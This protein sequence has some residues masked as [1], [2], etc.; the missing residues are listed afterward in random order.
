MEN[1]VSHVEDEFEKLAQNAEMKK[2]GEKT[3]KIPSEFSL[4]ILYFPEGIMQITRNKMII[5]G[6]SKSIFQ[7]LKEVCIWKSK[8]ILSEKVNIKETIIRFVL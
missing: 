5:K 4:R 3:F 6:A 2:K 1:Q 7:N 8:I